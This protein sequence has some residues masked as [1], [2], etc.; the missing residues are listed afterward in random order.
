MSD[1]I[2]TTLDIAKGTT[3]SMEG[4]VW[5][6]DEMSAPDISNLPRSKLTWVTQP[7]Y[8]LVKV[9]ERLVAVG[10]RNETVKLHGPKKSVNSHLQ[11]DR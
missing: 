1:N 8:M 11:I 7:E 10:L 9:D 6:K 4:L 2:C 5:A 3:G